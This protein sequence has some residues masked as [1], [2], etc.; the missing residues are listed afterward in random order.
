MSHSNLKLRLISTR[1]H[2]GRNYNLPSA[3]EV[4]AL[5]IGDVDINF[6]RRDIIVH[7]LS[8]YPQ[9]ID[10]LHPSYLALQY[11]LLFPRGED[12]YRDNIEHREETLSKTK[13]KKMLSMREY[14]AYRLMFR[15]NEISTLLHAG[16]LFQQFIVDGYTMIESQRLLWVRT[17]QKELRAYL[18]QGLID[19]LLSGERNASS[20]GKRVILP[21]SFTGGA[22]YMLGNYQDAMALCRYFG[23][24]S[25]FITFTCNPA[26]PEITRYCDGLSLSSSNR[27]DIL[28]RVFH[29]KLKALMSTVKKEKIFGKVLAD[30][31]TTEF[32]KRGLPHAHILLFLD[33]NDQL[34]EPTD[35]DKVISAE[36]PDRHSNPGLY[37]LVKRFMVHGP[38]GHLNRKSPC[39]K[40][41]K[42][43]KYFPKKFVATTTI[44]DDGY[45]TYRRRDDGRTIEVKGIPLDNRFVVPY[46]SFLLSIFQA[47]INVEK[48]NQSSAI[49]YLFKYI[50]KGHDRVVA[51]IYEGSQEGS[52]DCTAD[53]IHQYYNFRY[54]SACEAAWR[55]FA[56]EIHHRYPAVER[57]SFHLPN[58]Q[59]VVYSNNDDVADL[60]EKPRSCMSCTGVLDDDNEYI[61]GIKEA[62][63]WASGSMLRKMFVSMLLSSSL[64]RPEFVWEQTSKVLSEDL[65]FISRDDPM[66]SSVFISDRD[67]EEAALKE[68][69]LLLQHNGKSLI[70]YPSLPFPSS[71]P[72]IDV[73]NYLILQELNYDRDALSLESRRL[74]C[75]LNL[76][77]RKVFDI[78]MSALNSLHGA[79]FFVYGF[80]G[81]GKTFLWNAL[82]STIRSRGDIVLTVASSG[83]AATLL[84]S[85]RTAHSRFAIPLQVNEDSVCNIKQ[86]SPLANLLQV[87]KLIIW[88]EAPMVQR[89]CI[90][91]FDRTLKDIMHFDHPF[92]GKCVVMGG[93]FRQILP[94]I[95]KGSRADIINACICSSYLWDY[96][97]IFQLTVNMRLQSS[98]SGEDRTRTQKFCQW[99][100]DV[101][102]GKLGMPHDETA[103]IEIPSELL[104]SEYD[105]PIGAIV[106]S[107]YADLLENL[108]DNS[109]FNDR[110]ILAPTIDAVNRINEYMCSILPGESVDFYSCDSICKSSQDGDC[111]EDMYTTEFLNTINCS[112][113]PMHK[114]TLKIGTPIMLL[115]NIDQASGL[116]NGTRLRVTQLG[117]SI[118]EAVTLNG[119]MPNQKVLIHRMDMNPSDSRLPF[120]MRRRQFP[121][122]VSFAMTINKSQG[123][124]LQCVGLYL[125]KPVFTHGQLYVALSRVK[126]IDGLKILLHNDESGKKKL[127]MNVVYRE[128]FLNANIRC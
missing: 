61:N 97:T 46:N 126:S 87:T 81:T 106:S 48:C 8:G 73:R 110:A 39:M 76:D 100:L 95:P 23:Y 123:Q 80:G 11:P 70:D 22:R 112:G 52:S 6:C 24:P 118:I 42:C 44:D 4:A 25:I 113:M 15:E 124:S 1:N 79:F 99:L 55:I 33:K 63:L 32:Q 58:Q 93:D 82:T 74:I 27:P 119:S 2:N 101:G 53:E 98:S 51:S 41:N 111:I 40:D 47:H 50:S 49:K 103:E 92:G 104:I 37:D 36:I 83:I 54:I 9:R 45:P 102:D 57:L 10:E 68:I 91:A 85:G 96:C 17:H 62:S 13:K 3:P 116:C 71:V 115:R 77:Q 66:S 117:K 21:S 12:G 109:Y 125:P 5:I 120:R 16:N 43:S 35:I 29:M 20:I 122:S 26:W 107:T 128:V 67:R 94:V 7:E 121:I 90:E 30:V 19:A 34:K 28:S 18:Y 127:T 114:L 38:C 69:E 88:D 31:Y 60:I 59:Y 65:L 14:F 108:N 72:L 86:N 78:V 89:Y 56:F 105:D 84:P 75:L 64:S